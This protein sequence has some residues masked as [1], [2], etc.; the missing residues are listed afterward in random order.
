MTLLSRRRAVFQLGGGFGGLALAHLLATDATADGPRPDF[1]GGLHHPA[2]AKRVIQ[3][4]M[5]GG[6]S[7]MDTFDYKPE[8]FKLSGQKFDPGARVEAATSSP[9][10]V[11]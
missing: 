11:M 8:L 3:L 5:N 2:K 4:F 1:N 7:Q 9:G 6:A 10:S